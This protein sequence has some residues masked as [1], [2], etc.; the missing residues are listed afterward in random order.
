MS[1]LSLLSTLCAAGL[2]T[3][4]ACIINN[5]TGD[6]D[7]ATSDPDTGEPTTDPGETSNGETT[8][9]TDPGTSTVADTGSTSE[10][11][12]D[13][14][15]P[16]GCGWGQT[17]APSV[18]EGYVC[19]GDGADPNGTFPMDCPEDVELTEGA[20][21]G[22]IEGPGCCDSEGNVWFCADDGTGPVLY[23]EDCGA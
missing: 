11:P 12:T 22:S 20:E 5:N 7:G 1:R 19:G 9:P 21:C 2:L 14:G 8:D 6:D 23:T 18:P 10:D 16:V 17:G 4:P 15:G 3:T 13:T